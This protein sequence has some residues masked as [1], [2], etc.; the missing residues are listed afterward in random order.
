MFRSEERR[1]VAATATPSY[2]VACAAAGALLAEQARLEALA[3]CCEEA[4]RFELARRSS[5]DDRATALLSLADEARTIALVPDE[6]GGTEAMSSGVMRVRTRVADEVM[7]EE[8]RRAA[9]AES[10]RARGRRLRIGALIALAVVGVG[11]IGSVLA[12]QSGI[13]AQF[14]QISEADARRVI[15]ADADVMAGF[16][17]N[18]YV[19]ALP[20]E[21]TALSVDGSSEQDGAQVLTVS[22]SIENGR[23]RSSFTTELA[24]IRVADIAAHPEFSQ[25]SVPDGARGTDWIG[26]VVRVSDVE[27]EAIAGIDFDA[28]VDDPDFSPSFDRGHQ[29]CTYTVKDS[30]DLWFAEVETGQTLGYSFNGTRWVRRSTSDAVATVRYRGLDGSYHAQGGA[31]DEF[32]TLRIEDLDAQR[33]T[34]TLVYEKRATGLMGD[35]AVSG[36]ISCT[37]QRAESTPAYADYEQA[38]G[39]VYTFT[40]TGTSS[41]G[42]GTASVEGTL[43]DNY[44]L[45][46]TLTADYT[47]KPFLFGSETPDTLTVEASFVK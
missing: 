16:A 10:R 27:T 3:R 45:A 41:A 29:T 44:D 35:D 40:G 20:Y 26:R 2:A 6:S 17:E 11:G 28:E 13:F 36:S 8:E 46:L 14:S 43:G 25:A 19:E 39:A 22:A 5:S 31:A 21:L 12:V 47:R 42:N 18:D 32:D 15:A 1:C 34:F 38:D 9:A 37:I 23:F 4:S 7:A 24:F 30:V 33:G